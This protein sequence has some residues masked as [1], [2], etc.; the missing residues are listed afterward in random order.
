MK[1]SQDQQLL[2]YTLAW[3][4]GTDERLGLVRDLRTGGWLKVGG[5]T[6]RGYQV[7]LA[8]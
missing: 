1:L 7:M 5:E 8:L 3:Q 4:E 6:T 2:A